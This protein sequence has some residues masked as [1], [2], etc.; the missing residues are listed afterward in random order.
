MAGHLRRHTITGTTDH[1]LTGLVPSQLLNVNDTNTSVS[2]SGV[3]ALSG[4]LTATSVVVTNNFQYIDGSPG[5][6]KVLTSDASGNT[7]WQT[8][9]GI[10]GD[11]GRIYY[12]AP[13]QASDTLTYKKALTSPSTGVT[14][15]ITQTNTGTGDTLILTCITDPGEPGTTYIPPGIALR[16]IHGSTGGSNEVAR[17]KVDFYGRTTGG[18]ETLLRS[19]YS[20]PF[21]N[22]TIAEISWTFVATS[23]D[24][25][26]SKTDRLVLKLYTARVSGPTNVTV[27][28]YFEGDTVSYIKTT[29]GAIAG[30]TSAYIP[31]ANINGNNII[32]GTW[33]YSGNTIMPV[34]PLS[35]I[36]SSS[37]S[38]GTI[39]LNKINDTGST[40]GA[41]KLLVSNA[42]G[43]V[44]FSSATQ[45]GLSTGSTTGFSGWTSSTGV[46]SIKLNNATNLAG[47]S[48]ALVGGFDNSATTNYATVVNGRYN[49]ATGLYTTIVGGNGNFVN[50]QLSTIGGGNY[51]VSLGP[52]SFIGGGSS[53]SAITYYSSIVGGSMNI[54]LANHST[55]VS[56]YKNKATGIYSAILNGKNNTASGQRSAIIGG[57]G[58]TAFSADTVYVPFLNIQS[59]NTNNALTNILVKDTNGDISLRT[60]ASISGGGGFTGWTSSTG[61]NSIKL[62]DSTNLASGNFSLAGGLENTATTVYSVVVGGWRN[63]ASGSRS[64]IGGGQYNVA[65]NA[66]SFIGGGESH[67]A[68]GFMS[69]I[70]G[71]TNN[72]ASGAYSTAV[73][74]IYNSSNGSYSTIVGG[75][76]NGAA[77]IYSFIG[78]G[79]LNQINSAGIFSNII[80]G[81][82]NII[83][84]VYSSILNG[85][86]NT[87][88]G[89]SSSILAG[90]GH[91]LVG[92]NS[93]IIG[94]SGISGTSNNTVYVP[95]FNIQ[96]ASTNNA[97]L[98]VLVKDTNGDIYIRS[99]GTGSTLS[100]YTTTLTTPGANATNTITHN[101][102]TTGITVSLW[103]VTTGDLTNARVTNRTMNTVDVIFSSAP[104]ENID[105]V[106]QG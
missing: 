2:S 45:L 20:D 33:K 68:S 48:F 90:S 22:T 56:G 86:G 102:N 1:E 11:S 62:N 82:N 13:S 66:R 23:A 25:L 76:N 26:S 63:L 6:G 103:L 97:L 71:G 83:S 60:V 104:G 21:N 59:A 12:L 58:I 15:G 87:V 29:I 3:Y 35:N 47:G 70:A 95:F 8:S 54:A 93:A 42:A 52:F 17:Y 34:S 61:V 91:T 9:A 31:Q 16:V 41:G 36:G 4:S 96:S 49:L 18:T 92:N 85:S 100:K 81:K 46:N 14:T 74:G 51:N 77:A 19:G 69:T 101:L 99:I 43:S 32:D 64:F 39:F 80:G 84:G 50:G 72:T 5:S 37:N 75:S 28:S 88:P 30:L 7:F 94:G 10:L 53:N 105:V 27:N 73:G 40:F 79:L 65:S 55:V 89:S 24:T 78:G 106:V 57:Q 67:L 38:V 44:S 98:D